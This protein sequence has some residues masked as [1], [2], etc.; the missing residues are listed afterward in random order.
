LTKALRELIVT[1]HF[2]Q[3]P[4]EERERILEMSRANIEALMYKIHTREPF[5]TEAHEIRL[6]KRAR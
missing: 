3:T 6:S 4:W 2:A 5:L 1:L